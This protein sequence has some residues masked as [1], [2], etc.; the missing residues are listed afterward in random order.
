MNNLN[1]FKIDVC[2]AASKIETKI[3]MIY[4]KNDKI[5]SYQHS[6]EISKKC[7]KDP[8]EIE[9]EED[10]NKARKKETYLKVQKFIEDS[11]KEYDRKIRR[12]RSRSRGISVT[13]KDSK[14]AKY[15]KSI[16][17]S[18]LTDKSCHT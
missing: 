3:I 11:I 5:V 15:R 17:S 10:H 7:R 16:C 14:D 6:K 2:E 18:V 13:S 12:S 4:S 9:I 1:P 8:I